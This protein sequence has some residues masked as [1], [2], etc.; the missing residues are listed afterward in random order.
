MSSPCSVGSALPKCNLQT[1][2]LVIADFVRDTLQGLVTVGLLAPWQ[3][4]GPPTV[5]NGLGVV[6]NRK[7]KKRLVLDCRYVNAFV[8]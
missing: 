5:I 1:G 7:G 6:K 8:F 4:A 3:G 2:V